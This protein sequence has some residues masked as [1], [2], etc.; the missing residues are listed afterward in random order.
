MRV[1]LSWLR[2]HV[3]LPA[4]SPRDIAEKLTAAGLKVER[5]EHTGEGVEGVVVARVVEIEEL[6]AY[7]KPIRWVTLDDGN[8]RRQVICGA[9]NFAVGDVIAYARPPATLPGGFTITRRRAYDHDSDGMICSARELGI[10]DDHTGIVVLSPDLPL[11]ADVVD[12]LGLRDVVLDVAVNPDRGYALSVRGIARELAVAY[13]V[14]YDDPGLAG[15]A[16][17][18]APAWD[19]VIDDPTGCDRYVARLITAIDPKA[20]SPQ[21]LQRRLTLAGMRPISLAVDV[22]NHVMLDLGQPLHAFDRA[23]LTGAIVV[24]RARAAERI[25]TL[26]GVDRALDTDDLLITDGS[27]P[28][29]IAGV[30]G[31]AATEISSTTTDVVLEAAHFDPVSVAY[32]ARRHR[33]PSEASRRFERGVDD[34]LAPA[35]AQAAVDL[36]VRLGGAGDGVAGEGPA[37][38]DVDRRVPRPVIV[39]DPG[40][41]ARVSG[42]DYAEGA[43]R[44][45]LLDIG[46]SVDADPG[47]GALRVTV[48]SWRSDLRL[49]V[50]LVEEVAR[51]EGYD[52]LPTTV[53][54]PPPGRG[55]TR[56]QRLRRVVGR[57]LADAGYVEVLTY[58]F[59]SDA[60]SEALMLGADD[61]RRPTVRL[62]NPVSEEEPYLRPTLLPGLLAAVVRNVRRG[63]P[64]LALSETGPVFRLRGSSP[65]SAPS[66]PAGVRPSEADLRKLEEALPHQPTHLAVALTGERERSGWWGPGRVAAWPDAVEAARLVAGSLG[67]GLETRADVHAPWHP[68][69]CAA[70]LLDGRVVGHAGELHPR[71]VE[72]LGLPARTCAMELR[73]DDLLGAAPAEA[74]AGVISAFPPATFDLALVV[75]ATTPAADLAAALREGAGPL[76]ED[77]RLF[78]VFTGAQVGAGRKSLAFALRLRAP[79]RTL[80]A[81]EVAR[82][83][84][85]AVAAAEQ[86][87]GA[88]LRGG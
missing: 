59:V 52:R 5:L 74:R 31:G 49:P 36:L 16:T 84:E 67:L 21:W 70:L 54:T 14:P 64:D 46:C 39:L 4:P 42:V 78:D 65:A 80:T 28:I 76:L 15:P 87:C 85:A 11:G 10:G 18:S 24:R 3:E 13:G 44:R 50:D 32:T 17:Y 86:R 7:K 63:F 53:P 35:A 27:G 47:D 58:P 77:L 68:G 48:P 34:A 66:L 71:V 40:L 6:T 45:R 25:T 51:L 88:V 41:P 61:A 37:G 55:L 12:V 22:T 73:L 81:E 1:P 75:D 38:S 8:D 30:M 82:T 79:D 72:T 20:Q 69:R 43:A 83:R 2:S 57:T 26:D 56:T 29:A 33:L 9:T 19:V 62:A 23:R 60:V